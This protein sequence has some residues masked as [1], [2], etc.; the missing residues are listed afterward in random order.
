MDT[1]KEVKPVITIYNDGSYQLNGEKNIM[2]ILIALKTIA[3]KEDKYVVV[4]LSLGVALSMG[5][6]NKALCD[7]LDNLTK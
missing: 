5:A 4:S 2:P 3:E 7:R 1:Q 6:I